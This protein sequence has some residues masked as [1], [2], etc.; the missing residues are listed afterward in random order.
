MEH[1]SPRSETCT[2]TIFFLSNNRQ[3]VCACISFFIC[4]ILLLKYSSKFDKSFQANDV[5]FLS[6]TCIFSQIMP[7]QP[8]FPCE[9]WYFF[10]IKFLHPSVIQR[11]SCFCVI[12]WF[13]C[14]FYIILFFILIYHVYKIH[15][16]KSVLVKWSESNEGDEYK[17]L[18]GLSYSWDSSNS[19]FCAGTLVSS[20]S[21]S[22]SSPPPS[23]SASSSLS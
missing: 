5:V 8:H 21:S 11:K 7:I 23:S 6:V 4:W 17:Y 2:C 14:T 1:L 9:T 22:P 16:M 12:V 10:C 20:R 15:T 13:L 3:T 18:G 19:P